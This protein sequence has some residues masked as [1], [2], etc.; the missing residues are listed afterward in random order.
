MPLLF[1]LYIVITTVCETYGLSWFWKI[2]FMTRSLNWFLLG[3]YL[4]SMPTHKLEKIKNQQLLLAEILG[5]V[6]I[7]LP[8]LCSFNINFSCIGYLPLAMG[9]FIFCIKYPAMHLNEFVEY[10]GNE[11][12]L[13]IYIFHMPISIFLERAINKF[14]GEMNFTVQVFYPLLVVVITLGFSYIFNSAYKKI[15]TYKVNSK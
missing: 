1:I 7:V 5:C 15:K 2:N 8:T 12:A 14:S 4:H 3:Y 11:L 13:W 10:I 6:L 9:L